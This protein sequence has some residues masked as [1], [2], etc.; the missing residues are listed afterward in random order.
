MENGVQVFIQL[1]VREG[2]LLKVF[3]IRKF[4]NK[5]FLFPLEKIVLLQ[6]QI[7]RVKIEKNRM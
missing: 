6:K 4:R 1:V 7:I 2:K 5:L 3:G